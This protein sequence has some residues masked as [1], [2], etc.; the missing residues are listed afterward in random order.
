MGRGGVL[1]VDGCVYQVPALCVYLIAG[2]VATGLSPLDDMGREKLRLGL[3]GLVGLSG[4]IGR[5]CASSDS[6]TF[7]G[8]FACRGEFGGGLLMRSE[9]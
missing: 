4:L 6:A 3:V 8:L 5:C 9:L 1:V 7:D 2:S